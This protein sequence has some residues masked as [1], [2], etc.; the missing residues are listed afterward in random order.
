MGE[1]ESNDVSE[2]EDDM[3]AAEGGRDATPEEDIDTVEKT[4]FKS[5]DLRA[6]SFVQEVQFSSILKCSCVNNRS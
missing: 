6:S 2:R 1:Q 5:E 3:D 4:A